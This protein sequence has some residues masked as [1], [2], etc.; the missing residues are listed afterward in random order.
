MHP[1]SL[2]KA[3]VLSIFILLFVSFSAFAQAPNLLNYQGVARNTVGNPLPNQ[4]M[5]LRLSVHDLLPSG[6][7][8]YSEIRQIT[9]NLG[10]LFSVQIGSAGASSSTGTIAGVN[11][12]VGNKFLQVE[13]DPASNNNYL[14]IG[15]VQLVS[16]PYAFGAGT[17]ATVKTNA[18]LTGVV[19]SVGNATAIANGAITS[20]MIGTINQT[21]V[22][23]GS[24]NNTSDIAKPISTLT[25]AALDLKSNVSDVTSL[26]ENKVDK[27][28]GKN[29]STNDYTTAEKEKLAA[30]TGTNTVVQDLSLYAT[31]TSLSNSLAG[32]VDKVSGKDLSTNDFTTTEKNKLSSITGTN[33]GDQDLSLYATSTSVAVKENQSNKSTDALLGGTNASDILFPTQKAVKDYVAANSS[34]GGV[35]DG[36]I[37]TIKLADGAV[38]DAKINTVSGSKLIGNITGNAATATLATTAT[39]AGNITAT[40]NTTLTSLSNLATVGTITSGVWSGTAVAVEKGGTGATTVSAARTNLGLVNVDNTSDANKP[41]STAVQSALDLKLNATEGV[42][43][44]SRINNKS[45]LSDTSLLNLTSRF[46]S[47]LNKTDTSY[48]LLGYRTR[49][50]EKLNWIDTTAMLSGYIH[51]TDTSYMLLGYRT[52]INNK[53]NWIDTTAMLSKYLR[54]ADTSSLSDR[55]NVKLNSTVF[56]YYPGLQKGH[57]M[58]WN[59]SNWVL[60][61]PGTAG[62]VLKMSTANEPVPVWGTDA[63][64]STTAF[65][66]CGATI[67]D[68]DGNAYNTVLIGSQC[69]T[70]E[71]LRVRK[72]NN[73]TAIQFDATGGSG[74]SS[75]TWQNLTIGAHTIYA[76]DSITTPSNLTKYGYLYNWYAAKGIN[77]NGTILSNDTLNICPSG[78]HVPTDAEWTT[79]TTELGGESVAGGKMKSIGTTYWTSQSAGTD[80]SSSFSALPG[81]F[82][83]ANGSFNN[84]RNSAA[85]WSATEFNAN[86]AWYR[87]L[88]YNSSNVSRISIEKQ[89]GAS[90][91]C[92]K[93]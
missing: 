10:G 52:Q 65:S 72:Y 75:S 56:P 27:V 77:T 35:V 81:G 57:I 73:G 44:S 83:I 34:S 42:S 70:K 93:D 30:I 16:V 90:I 1:I 23:L 85:F 62:Q 4:T 36:G 84:L 91:R 61:N 2:L 46:D 45:S 80:N 31:T 8:V 49:I 28:V 60:L 67:T 71:N 25:Q 6:A 86:S 82:R 59:G 47:K 14:D 26:L 89:V 43:L 12:I 17:A 68:I 78:W 79:L 66:P 87:R 41:V 19:T 24:V 5:K 18:N 39:T 53:L 29:L 3:K 33:T 15:T 63:T 9:T 20:D 69:W 21:K 13:L 51:K 11:W 74:G 58:Y 88:D 55:I 92:I 64:T 38:T 32:K 54:K 37:T 76:N 40:T 22:G 7:V 50:N 48:M